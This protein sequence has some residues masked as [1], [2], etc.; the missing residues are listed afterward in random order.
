MK[1]KDFLAKYA[2]NGEYQVAP[3]GTQLTMTKYTFN[4]LGKPWT[5]LCDSTCFGDE[6]F[7][8]EPLE[9]KSRAE[10]LGELIDL[11]RKGAQV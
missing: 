8:L 4:V 3:A 5:G 9:H 11:A 6:I 7:G 2:D 10:A 1:A